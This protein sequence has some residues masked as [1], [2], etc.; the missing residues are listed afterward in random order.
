MRKKRVIVAGLTSVVLA[1][2]AAACTIANG[3]VLPEAQTD[4]GPKGDAGTT[5]D[6]YVDPCRSDM[7]PGPPD[8]PVGTGTDGNTYFFAVDSVNFT[9]PDGG[10]GVGL[11]LD[12]E[13]TCNGN[14]KDPSSCVPLTASNQNCDISGN[15]ID[16]SVGEIVIGAAKQGGYDV[17]GLAQRALANGR[18]GLLIK[19]EQYNGLPNDSRVVFTFY[20]SGGPAYPDGGRVGNLPPT[21]TTADNWTVDVKSLVAG[22]NPMKYV[23]VN[24]TSAT[25]TNGVFVATNLS[26]VV[27]LD[28]GLVVDLKSMELTGKLVK[29][30]ENFR[31]DDGVLAGRWTTSDALRNL[32][33]LTDPTI[34]SGRVCD[35]PLNYGALKLRIC[36][37]ADISSTGPDNTNVT[38]DALSLGLNYSAKPAA[39][40][41][42]VDLQTGA[43]SCGNVDTNCMN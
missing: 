3:L 40:G 16:N 5:K 35:N 18:N 24:S 31:I 42:I 25:V 14:P 19:M 39:F 6:A 22:A 28:N 30:G 10:G 37:A 34:D 9:K 20:V 38:C 8:P 7:L 36:S 17:E 29:D 41:A 2:V 12:K 15:G 4:A 32:G 11:N 43:P 1:C 13:C 26:G 33:S 23:G 21:F 27:R